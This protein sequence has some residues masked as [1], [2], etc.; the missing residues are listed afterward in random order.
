MTRWRTSLLLT[1]L[2]CSQAEVPQS[3]PASDWRAIGTEPFWRLDVTAAGLRF[4]TPDDTM[5]INVPPLMSRLLGDTTGWTGETERTRVD[6]RI[7]PASCSDGMSDRIWP[8]TAL[9][10]ID[11]KTWRGCAEPLPQY[12]LGKW[13]V[14][15]HQ[16]P[17]I[18][19]MN[20]DTAAVWVGRTA[21]YTST[22]AVF[23]PDE[24]TEP[25]YAITSLATSGFAA[26]F[27]VLPEAL[28][29]AAPVT[30]VTVGCR[31]DWTVPGNRLIVKGPDRLFTLWD[32]VFFELERQV[33]R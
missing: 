19:A 2:A 25:N 14:T 17:G 7:W 4:T 1:L 5:G 9:V 28:G 20:P 11:G 21:E 26:E 15:A 22:R 12:H 29:L 8:A 30:V 24:C 16:A 13:R 6:V 23:G 33:D 27:G 31:G 10:E 32:G 3:E 18:S